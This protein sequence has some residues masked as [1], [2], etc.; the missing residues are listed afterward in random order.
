MLTIIVCTVSPS[1]L[2]TLKEN[3]E[4]TVGIEYE[5]LVWDNSRENKGICEVYNRMAVL[6][7]YSNL[8]F[9]HEDIQ[10]RT[11]AWGRYVI[12]LLSNKE[13]GLIGIAGGKYKSK[14]LSGWYSGGQDRDYSNI[15]HKVKDEEYHL[16]FPDHWTNNEIEVV[17]IDGAFMCC[18]KLT[19]EKIKFNEEILKGFHFYDID[20]SL[21]VA[22]YKKVIVTNSINIEHFTK[23]GD[24]GD[25][26]I[27]QAFIFH[28][29]YKNMLPYFTSGINV[30]NAERETA[31]YWLDWL[32]DQPVSL[33][34]RLKWVLQQKLYLSIKLWYS[35][36]KFF[37][38]RP[39]RLKYIHK[40]VKR[41]R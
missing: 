41:F 11:E 31:K 13:I 40:M 15:L 22:Q 1:F 20:F 33:G 23:G 17:C 24:F 14:L 8:C 27:E 16:S 7:K 10:F 21:R 30:H 26:W 4:S 25:K 39:L 28:K 12:D 9:I 5:W 6:A 35:I 36:I 3:V 37:L 18:T 38:Y 2:N 19:W 32:K 34:N 29:A